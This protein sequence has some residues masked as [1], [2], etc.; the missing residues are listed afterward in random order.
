MSDKFMTKLH[1]TSTP[2]NWFRTSYL[3][4]TNSKYRTKKYLQE[5]VLEQV[6]DPIQQIALKHLITRFKRFKSDDTKIVAIQNWVINHI[7]YVTD[8]TKYGMVE[9]WES[10]LEVYKSMKGDCE[11]QAILIYCLARWS[12][13]IDLKLWMVIGPTRS[14]Y[15]CWLR[16]LSTVSDEW[17]SIDTTYHPNV[18]AL[19]VRGCYG[20]DYKYKGEDAVFNETGAY[21][22]Q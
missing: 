2:Q 4:I 7:S 10:P 16:Y 8:Q 14:D 18:D 1:N 19:S 5:F 12:G 15:H 3:W 21:V 6:T 20:L 11:S 9:R 22:Y 13:I 17:F